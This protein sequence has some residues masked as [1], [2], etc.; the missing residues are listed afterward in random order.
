MFVFVLVVG[1]GS[2]YACLRAAVMWSWRW[3]LEDGCWWERYSRMVR[4]LLARGLV[5]AVPRVQLELWASCS[6]NMVRRLARVV[7]LPRLVSRAVRA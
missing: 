3:V 6:M 5:D 1:F 2:G 4:R 7:P